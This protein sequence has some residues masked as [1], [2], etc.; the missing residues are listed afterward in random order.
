MI[1]HLAVMIDGRIAAVEYVM[2][3][4][5]EYHPENGIVSAYEQ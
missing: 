5:P 3:A 1:G 2:H 4:T